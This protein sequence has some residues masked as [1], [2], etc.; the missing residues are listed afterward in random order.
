MLRTERRR[1]LPQADGPERGGNNDGEEFRGR[2]GGEVGA[3]THGRFGVNAEPGAPP[4]SSLR[5]SGE[6]VKTRHSVP[7]KPLRM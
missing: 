1:L 5:A 2:L 4:E 3:V 7:R 6:W